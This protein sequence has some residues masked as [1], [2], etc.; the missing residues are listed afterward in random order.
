VYSNSVPPLLKAE[1]STRKMTDVRFS[2]GLILK[3]DG[4][5]RDVIP[6]SPAAKAGISGGMKLLGVNNRRWTPEILRAAISGAQTNTAPIELLIE[7]DEYFK[8]C[9]LDY[10]GGEKYPW[11]EREPAKPDLLTD[12]LKPLTPAP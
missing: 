11:L 9:E 10:H 8:S 3:E 2:L 5:V 1:E 6:G 4:A 7:N 12:I